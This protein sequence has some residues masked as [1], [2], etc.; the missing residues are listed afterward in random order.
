VA[1]EGTCTAGTHLKVTEGR[2]GD[3]Y[4]PACPTRLLLDRVGSKW[5]VMVV[6]LLAD[7]GEL[8]FGALVRRAAGISQKMLTQTLRQLE[9]DGLALRR[10]E[11]TRPPAVH[12]S[13]TPLGR[14]LV[15]PLQAMKQWAEENMS[16]IEDARGA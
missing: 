10:I 14:T 8:R 13:L 1:Q 2:R 3:L 5:T 12:Y 9:D 11:P 7:E 16:T 15:P 6:L 4:E